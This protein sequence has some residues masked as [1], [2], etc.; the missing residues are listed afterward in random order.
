[1]SL[2]NTYI[3]C[4]SCQFQL[5]SKLED[6]IVTFG[7]PSCYKLFHRS[8]LG[9]IEQQAFKPDQNKFYI[10]LGT[11]G[12]I[13]GEEAWLIAQLVKRDYE[14]YSWK[15]YRVLTESNK[16]IFFTEYNGN[17]IKVKDISDD[18]KF[19]L[20]Q[21]T[22]RFANKDYRKYSRYKFKIHAA[23]G[24]F[25]E[26]IISETSSEIAEFISPPEMVG[27]EKGPRKMNY[28]VGEHIY[29]EEIQSIFNLKEAPPQ[30]TGQGQLELGKGER[31]FYDSLYLSLAGAAL[32]WILYLVFNFS[33]LSKTVYAWRYDAESEKIV[34]TTPIIELKGYSKN[35]E[36]T[37]GSV[38]D[39]NWLGAQ[40]DFVNV[41][42]GNIISVYGEIEQYHGYTDG[43][44]W[45]EGSNIGSFFVSSIPGGKYRLEISFQSGSPNYIFADVTIKRDVPF[46]RNLLICLALLAL[47]PAILYYINYRFEVGRWKN[48]NYSPYDSD[49]D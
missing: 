16:I 46:I 17:W 12:N 38:L 43:E 37:L 31:R 10:P 33:S 23:I 45:R 25:N 13:E 48:S 49:D 20:H 32:L 8:G 35:V 18:L 28:F 42:T 29:G 4:P 34:H 6:L 19:N 40:I 30:K 26:N 22:V 7:C 3:V 11:K 21:G 41:E 47:Y 27:I 9:W 39:N 2:G 14:G 24:E 44:N 15:E 1:M 36:I 5:H